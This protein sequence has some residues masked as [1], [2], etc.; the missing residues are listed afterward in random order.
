MRDNAS[1]R[2][3]SP[4]QTT[5]GHDSS[6]LNTYGKTLLNGAQCYVIEEEANYRFLA[7]SVLHADGRFVVEPIDRSGRWVR[8]GGTFGVAI[9]RDGK[10]Q[11]LI[12]F[13]MD[14]AKLVYTGN[15]SRL[16]CIA[17]SSAPSGVHLSLEIERDK[18][19][20]TFP[21]AEPMV[22]LNPGDRIGVRCAPVAGDVTVALTVALA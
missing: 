17:A 4:R 13:A 22:V 15:V 18:E 1:L 8:E 21:A 7:N 14:G 6:L 2:I 11:L 3:L 10:P 12:Q 20:L 19:L 5:Q 16:A 9:I